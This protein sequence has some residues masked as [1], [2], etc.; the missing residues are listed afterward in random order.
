MTVLFENGII[1]AGEDG[2]EVF[3]HMTVSGGVIT[4]LFP[5]RPE[6]KFARVV[7]LRGRHVY[8]CLIDAHVHLLLT[9]AVFVML[10]I[11]IFTDLP[12]ALTLAVSLVVSL[13]CGMIAKKH[14]WLN[15][16]IMAIAM[17][18]A[19]ASSVLWVQLFVK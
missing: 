4:G 19:M 15:D 14:K 5:D 16:F 17:I 8:P 12:T 7:D 1:H 6:G 3:S 2:K 13:I 9:V 11:M 10:P 18:V